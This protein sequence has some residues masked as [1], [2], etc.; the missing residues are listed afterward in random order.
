MLITF[1]LEFYARY[2]YRNLSQA[3]DEFELITTIDLILSIN[4]ILQATPRTKWAGEPMRK[5][6]VSYFVASP[7]FNTLL[8]YLQQMDYTR[9]N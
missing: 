9:K 2:Y 8:Y 4:L 6:I 3:C 7:L 5:I 1:R